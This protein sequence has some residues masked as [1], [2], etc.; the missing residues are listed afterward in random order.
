MQAHIIIMT[1][2]I[3]MSCQILAPENYVSM[4]LSFNRY[5]GFLADIVMKL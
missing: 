1:M 3:V 4:Q 5:Y 2:Y